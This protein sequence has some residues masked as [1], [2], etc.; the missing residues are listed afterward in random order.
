MEKKILQLKKACKENSLR[1]TT[2]REKIFLAV[3]NSCSH[4]DVEQVFNTV[5]QEVGDISM[6]T[7]YRNLQTLENLKLIFRVDHQIPKA[8]FDA[9]M[10]NHCHFIC[11]KCGEIY[12]IFYKEKTSIPENAKEF[13][14]IK[15]VNLQVKGICNKCISE[16]KK[17]KNDGTKRQQN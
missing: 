12:D 6:D 3:A 1:Y 10:T 4:P 13:G 9:D 14:A 11:T 5:K 15:H 16:M 7:I 8:R 2:Q 17:E